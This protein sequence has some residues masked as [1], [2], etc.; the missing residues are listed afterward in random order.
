[1]PALRRILPF[2]LIVALLGLSIPTP[3]LAVSTG[4]EVQMG[5]QTDKD[6]I[7]GTGVVRDPLL[8]SWVHDVSERLWSQVARKDVP[9]NIKVLDTSDIN[10]FSTLG[11]YVYLNEGLLDFVQ[12]DDELASV[13]G[14]ETG[15]I[16]RRHGV[17]FPAKAQ[18]LNL[19]FGIAS[20]FSPLVYRFGQIAQAGLLAKLSRADE[21]Q[22]DQYGLLLSSRAG[23]DP[24]ATITNLRHLNALHSEHPDALTHYLETHP[25]PPARISHLLGYEQLNPKTRT[26]QQL[27]VQAIHDEDGARFNI[28]AMKFNQVLKTEPNNAVALL[29]LGQ[30]QVALGQM[31]R[32]EQSLAAAAEKGTPETRSVALGRI[33]GLRAMHK[34]R[35]LLQPNLTL[36]REQLEATKAQQTQV[37][38]TLVSRRDAGRDQLK[39]LNARLESIS[40]EL[41]NFGRIDIRSGSRLE[42]VLKNIEGMAR[43]IDTTLDHGSYT[44]NG[45]GSLEKNKESGLL[46]DNADIL[47][48]MQAPLNVSP[49]TPDSIA[50]LPSYPRMFSEINASNG[51]MI[52]AVDA[53]RASIAM[54]DVGLGDL[55]IF[56]KALHQHA[57]IDYFG[58][59]SQNDYNA[60][61]PSMSTAN[62]SLGKTAVAASAAAQ[63]FNMARSRQLETRVTLLGVGTTPERYA[64]LQKSLR[65]RVKT[66]GLSYA[67]MSHAG[68]TPGEV[69]A[70]TIVA[71]DTNTS[72]SAVIQQ[73]ESSH[74]TIVDIANAR[75]MHAGSLEIFL[76]LIYLN[77]VDDPEKEAHN[78]T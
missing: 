19:L 43:S 73:A 16:E 28:A 29:Y 52:R 47:K 31:N 39:T 35:S 57:N 75:G 22:A 13:I 30:A 33:A 37:A 12:S 55:D 61:L 68:L 56:L 50:L 74:R 10:A 72:P 11:G 65:V 44:I 25:D 9:Y 67:A 23:Y 20:L 18:A 2:T 24:D 58:D 14:H 6:I 21:I 26:A 64:S 62:D 51:D 8:N 4:T 7:A 36:L 5:K 40:Y 41:P 38:A 45:I 69:A 54:L 27:L 77:Y 63:L 59:I 17:T 53:G 3:A 71:A 15:H 34:R 76:G 66:E 1:M 49:M 46:K 32:G 60:I 42:T 70:A 78:V 48:E